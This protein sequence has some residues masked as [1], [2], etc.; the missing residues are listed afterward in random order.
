MTDRGDHI[1]LPSGIS[2]RDLAEEI[3]VSVSTVSRALSGHDRVSQRTIDDVRRAIAAISDRRNG[4]SAQAI[5]DH[6]IGLTTSHVSGMQS[7]TQLDQ[8]SGQVLGG[9]EAAANRLGYRVY[10]ARNS[11]LFFA[12]EHS[13]FLRS[14]SGL[15]LA[16][17]MISDEVLALAKAARVPICI[18]GGHLAGSDIPSVASDFH[19]GMFL[20]TRHLIELGHTRIALVN[21]PPETYTSHEKHAGYLRA[22]S[23]A[24][25]PIDPLLIKSHTA[26]GGFDSVAGLHTMTELFSQDDPP[27]G[28]V[29]ATDDIAVGGVTLLQRRGIRVPDD[30]SIV[31]FQDDEVATATSPR[32][33]TIRVDRAMWGQCAVERLIS[34]ANGHPMAGDR[35]LLP[36]ELIIREST[37]R[38]STKRKRKD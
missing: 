5:A 1:S 16:G 34:I 18:V 25:L 15:I 2:Q 27:T 33:T 6:M 35:L 7:M 37:A 19:Y 8:I 21:G 3:G 10:T 20:A 30:V 22:L 31:G 9:A 4:N 13:A 23:E 11:K 36:V 17:G 32:L 14:M 29:T 38:V 26:F 28:I 12:D 24:D